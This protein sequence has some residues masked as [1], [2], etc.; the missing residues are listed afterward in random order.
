[1]P[2]VQAGDVKLNYAEHGRGDNIIVYIHGNLGCVNWMDLVWEKL[3]ESLHVYAIEWRGCGESDKPE[4]EE[5]F[6]N[7]TMVQHAKDIIRAVKALGIKKCHLA[8][9]STGGI[10]CTH[11]LLMEPDVFGKV[12]CLD[13]VGPM[14]LNMEK[15]LELFK[16]MSRSRDNAWSVMATAAPTLFQAES[17]E[18]GKLPRFAEKVMDKQKELYD[19]LIDKTQALS[20]GIWIGT[21]VNLTKEY[22]SGELKK[23]LGEIKHPHLI[24]WGEKDLWISREDMEEMAK[25]LPDCELKIL[26]GVGHS[27]NVEDPARFAQIFTEYFT[28]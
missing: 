22:R 10:I 3:P 12:F 4:P 6:K 1:M 7:Y 21:A 26:P 13:P 20:E 2:K 18:P 25:L 8:N 24:V 17:L 23:R 28:D 9:H 14:G 27:L 11:M 16:S 5:D 19:L 15:S